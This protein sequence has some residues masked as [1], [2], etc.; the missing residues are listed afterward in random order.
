MT[1]LRTLRAAMQEQGRFRPSALPA[2][3]LGWNARDSLDGMAPGFAVQL[4]NFFPY[5]GFC[6]LRGGSQ[7]W[8]TGL[9]GSVDTLARWAD[10]SIEKIVAGAGGQ[11]WL[12][13]AGS[14]TSL[15][16]GFT[17]NDWQWDM[18]TSAR[19]GG[20]TPYLFLTNGSDTPQAY[21][22]TTVAP[23]TWAPAQGEPALTLA[24]LHNIMVAKD[25]IFL[26]EKGQLGFW[27]GTKGGGTPQG[28]LYWFDLGTILRDGGEIVDM[29][30]MTIEGGD[31]PDDYVLFIAST[32][33]V[34]VYQGN[35]P[36]QATEWGLVGRYPL[37]R[38]LGKRCALEIAG[39]VIVLT[40]NGYIS[41][42]QFI[43]L[44]GLLRQSFAFNDNIQPE[45]VRQTL[46]YNTTFGWQPLLVPGLTLALFNV[47]QSS[48]NFVQHVVNTQTAAW[49]RLTDW[50]G[51]SWLSADND[52]LFG[53]PG[54]AIY[55]ANVG[56]VDVGQ[57]AVHGVGITAFNDFGTRGLRKQ[58]MMVRPVLETIGD[59]TVSLALPV[60]Y[61]TNVMLSSTSVPITEAAAEWNVDEWNV[62]IWAGAP[63]TRTDWQ[64]VPAF[65][66][67]AAMYMDVVSTGTQCRWKSA[68][69]SH[70]VGG[71]M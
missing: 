49:A 23:V 10:A 9:G 41:M 7:E 27:H 59:V 22:G 39:D 48:G 4:D 38:A 21:D 51:T 11:L 32:G 70:T 30:T 5:N 69:I 20:G 50:N 60:D 58:F 56:G 8:V 19:S 34:A 37:G 17:G 61:D 57:Q 68:D 33:W 64:S 16:S 12:V 53:T 35:D 63:V 28:D 54:G 29:A 66:Y 55:L 15:A 3:V 67:S 40:V 25:V 46:D 42:R 62:G 52:L 45:V 24:N 31:G 47:P 2:P 6:T 14:S 1:S 36:N 43:Q 26:A 18:T 71:L 65:G 44:G 13:S